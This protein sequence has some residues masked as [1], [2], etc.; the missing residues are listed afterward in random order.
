MSDPIQRPDVPRAE[1]GDGA[2]PP[3]ARRESRPK[4]VV[5]DL[6][7]TLA[8]DAGRAHY[9]EVEAG[10]DRDWKS[11]FDAVDQ[12]APIASSIE[13]LHA[14]REAGVRVVY[15]TGRP[16]FTRP[17][18]ERW[19]KANGLDEFDRLVM[20]PEGER[21]YA[22]LFKVDEID[23]LREEYE[24]VCAF[25]DRIDVAQHLRKAGLPVYLYGA[26]AEA[27]AESLEAEEAREGADA[28]RLGGAPAAWGGRRP[29]STREVV[30]DHLALARGG[31][32]ETDLRRNFHPDATVLTGFGV[33][34]GLEGMREA[35]RLLERQL[36][37]GR[38]DYVTV[39]AEGEVGF[40]EWTAEGEGTVVRDGVDTFHVEDGRIRVQTIHYRVE[41][42][43]GADEG[44][45]G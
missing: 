37:A 29:R 24:L 10:R 21:R 2:P 6:D 25:E 16:E 28:Q 5:W 45:P 26:G 39:L 14:L 15:L 12:D 35:A 22:G 7:G 8:D 31:D 33:F 30:E 36:P 44:A 43:A 20:R 1:E 13:I 41:S 17:K 34:R 23:R 11:Y 32:L 18:T 27:A 19:L 3:S 40:L 4:A 42:A 38:Y 9:V